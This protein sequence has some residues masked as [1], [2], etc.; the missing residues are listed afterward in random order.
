[1]AGARLTL[2]KDSRGDTME[3]KITLF[4]GNVGDINLSQINMKKFQGPLYT[5]KPSRYS[6]MMIEVAL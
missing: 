4:W 5:T 3:S 1:M 2:I 6:K